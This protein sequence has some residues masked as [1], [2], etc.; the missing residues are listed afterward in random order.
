MPVRGSRRRPQATNGTARGRAASRCRGGNQNPNIVGARNAATSSCA[1]NA[2]AHME[3][4]RSPARRSG[5]ARESRSRRDRI[6][7]ARPTKPSKK[8]GAHR[9]SP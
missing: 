6:S 9:S 3:A 2:M 7:I 8:T 5:T 1:P 4:T